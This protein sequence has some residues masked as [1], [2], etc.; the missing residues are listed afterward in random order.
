MELGALHDRDEQLDEPDATI[1]VLSGLLPRTKYRIYVFARTKEGRGEGT[2]IEDRTA[3]EEGA[4]K[5]LNFQIFKILLE[6]KGH[7][8]FLCLYI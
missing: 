7:P 5:V 1:T 4:V 8:S 6:S 2:F 3:E